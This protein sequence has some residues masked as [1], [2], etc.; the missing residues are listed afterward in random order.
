MQSKRNITEKEKAIY[1][2]LYRVIYSLSYGE[3]PQVNIPMSFSIDH[4]PF[5]MTNSPKFTIADLFNGFH[6]KDSYKNYIL[7]FL[8]SNFSP[9]TAQEMQKISFMLQGAGEYFKLRLKDGKYKFFMIA[10]SAGFIHELSPE[11]KK[12]IYSEKQ[13]H[14]N[15]LRPQ[16][17]SQN[18]DLDTYFREKVNSKQWG[19][20]YRP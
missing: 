13:V 19:D 6:L 10:P 8:G 5:G 4:H 18:L 12:K 16:T 3:A 7:H 2:F 20:L 9:C 14:H 1:D 11:L 15:H 17:T